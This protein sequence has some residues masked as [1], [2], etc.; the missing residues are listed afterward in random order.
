MRSI[1]ESHSVSVLKKEISKTN[2]KGYSKMKKAEVVNLMLKHKARFSHIKHKE[3]ATSVKKEAPKKEAPKPKKKKLKLKI[4]GQ[5]E[6]VSNFLGDIEAKGKGTRKKVKSSRKALK[7]PEGKVLDTDETTLPYGDVSYA[8]LF[9]VRASDQ[10]PGTEGQKWSFDQ[11]P[12]PN[13][14]R[15]RNKDTYDN[16]KEDSDYLNTY[17]SRADYIGKNWEYIRSMKQHNQGKKTKG[18]PQFWRWHAQNPGA[19]D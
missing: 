13:K 1:L 12:N 19:F 10:L 4:K 17:T 7:V 14:G 2:I 6:K 9:N 8:P 18:D 3:K 5:D 15:F 16:W 11:M